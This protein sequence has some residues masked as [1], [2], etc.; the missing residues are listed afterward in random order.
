MFFSGCGLLARS[1]AV[2]AS[3][4]RAVEQP[5]YLGLKNMALSVFFGKTVPLTR[6]KWGH[7]TSSE[8]QMGV[9]STINLYWG[10]F[11][12]GFTTLL[13]YHQFRY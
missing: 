9:Y 12:I 8:S 13:L 2:S 5:W 10:G 7:F 6:Q 11:D 4:P 1:L 3:K